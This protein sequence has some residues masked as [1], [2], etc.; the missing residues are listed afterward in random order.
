MTELSSVLRDVLR[1][2]GVEQWERMGLVR[3]DALPELGDLH[4]RPPREEFTRG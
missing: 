3:G 2:L 1:A 4:A